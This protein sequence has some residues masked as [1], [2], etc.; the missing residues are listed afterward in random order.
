MSLA[1]AS[2]LPTPV[3]RPRIKRYRYNRRTTQ[4]H[5]HIRQ[6]LQAGGAW[7]QAGQILEPRKE[8]V[9]SREETFNGAVKNHDFHVLVSLECR[10]DLV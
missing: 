8:V 9:M 2:S 3:A 7:R 10:D 6:R 1:S 4:A 5:E